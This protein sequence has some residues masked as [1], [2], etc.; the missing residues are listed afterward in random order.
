MATPLFDSRACFSRK[1]FGPQN[2][3]NLGHERLFFRQVNNTVDEFFVA[4]LL[5]LVDR[6]AN[7]ENVDLCPLTF[8]LDYFAIAEG[9]AERWKPLEKIGDLAHSPKTG[10]RMRWMQLPRT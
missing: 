6:P 8:Q 2:S 1:R 3:I 10:C 4:I 9:L 7:R 5:R